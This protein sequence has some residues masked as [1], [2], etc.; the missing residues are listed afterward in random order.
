[1]RFSEVRLQAA[2]EQNYVINILYNTRT[3]LLRHVT[4][5]KAFEFIIVI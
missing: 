4:W 5:K 2:F 3:P 1:M